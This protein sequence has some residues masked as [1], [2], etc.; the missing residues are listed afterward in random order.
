MTM[1]MKFLQPLLCPLP[2]LQSVHCPLPFQPDHACSWTHPSDLYNRRCHRRP[3]SIWCRCVD[4]RRT[5]SRSADRRRWPWADVGGS[6]AVLSRASACW[7]WNLR[8]LVWCVFFF[9]ICIGFLFDICWFFFWY[10]FGIFGI[11]I[12]VVFVQKSMRREIRQESHH[13]SV[14]ISVSILIP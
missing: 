13:F 5:W 1:T 2:C 7:F 6:Y 10:F 11:F 14:P 4:A 3:C 9:G 8:S 12:C